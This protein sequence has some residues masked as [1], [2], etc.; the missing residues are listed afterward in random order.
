[1]DAERGASVRSGLCGFGCVCRQPRQQP[2]ISHGLEPNYESERVG[3]WPDDSGA[4][5][6]PAFWK[7]RRKLLRCHFQLQRTANG[8]DQA[9]LLRTDLP[10]ELCVVALPG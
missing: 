6:V 4:T 8:R 3:G 10:G 9:L 5:A 1:M 7:C 2:A